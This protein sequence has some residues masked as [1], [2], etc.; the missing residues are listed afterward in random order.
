MLKT[1]K[2]FETGSVFLISNGGIWAAYS[3]ASHLGQPILKTNERLKAAI[4][5]IRDRKPFEH[6]SISASLQKEVKQLFLRC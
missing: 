5:A 2:P 1:A 4:P 6:F 3:N